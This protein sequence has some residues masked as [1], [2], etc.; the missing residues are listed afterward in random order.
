MYVEDSIEPLRQQKRCHC[1][2]LGGTT[3]GGGFIAPH[4]NNN[5]YVRVVVGLAIASSLQI[6]N[7]NSYRI[8][9][10]EGGGSPS[11]IFTIAV[12]KTNSIRKGAE[13]CLMNLIIHCKYSRYV[14]L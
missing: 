11:K 8:D 3:G 5:C 6:T 1:P 12:H 10:V 7:C 14:T 9:P 13:H 4:S 2:V